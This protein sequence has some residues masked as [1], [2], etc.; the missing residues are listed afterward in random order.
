MKRKLET[1]IRV[2]LESLIETK[3]NSS[4]V[5][6]FTFVGNHDWQLKI[7]QDQP[8]NSS[9]Y[10]VKGNSAPNEWKILPSAELG[11]V[12]DWFENIDPQKVFIV[13]HFM[14]ICF[15][16]KFLFLNLLSKKL[17]W[18]GENELERKIGWV[19]FHKIFHLT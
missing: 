16:E 18:I 8:W 19:L 6:K 15:K 14:I 7:D 11:V 17:F 2:E 13:K 1:N 12:E 4:G 3:R 10:E 9:I 5:R